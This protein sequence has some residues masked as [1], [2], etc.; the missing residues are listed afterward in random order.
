MRRLVALGAFVLSV[1]AAVLGHARGT[2]HRVLMENVA[3]AP[4]EIT[5]R[6]GDV[7]EWVNRDF[8]AHTATA[9]NAG[10]DVDLSPG[11]TGRVTLN[12]PGEASYHCRYHPNMTGRIVVQP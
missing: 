1:T 10:W 2:T 12:R 4:A 3:F 5:V 8:V 6:V 9:D 7:V 11:A